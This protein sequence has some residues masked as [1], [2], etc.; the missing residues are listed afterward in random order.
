MKLT[1]IVFKDSEVGL[2]TNFG[3][4]GLKYLHFYEQLALKEWYIPKEVSASKVYREWIL[5]REC[6]CIYSR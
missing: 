2:G 6:N 4:N 3:C 1:R 5:K